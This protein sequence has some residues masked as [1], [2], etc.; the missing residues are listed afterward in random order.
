[1]KST[2]NFITVY[3]FPEELAGK[4]N[5]RKKTGYFIA[6]VTIDGIKY[7]GRSRYSAI[8][9]LSK[10]LVSAGIPDTLL[11]VWSNLPR[12]ITMP[13]FHKMAKWTRSEMRDEKIYW[14]PKSGS[15]TKNEAENV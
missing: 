11:K 13:S 9:A 7:K 14:R 10:E 3:H 6:E 12:P 8:C 15:S 1:M 4:G 5:K 2:L